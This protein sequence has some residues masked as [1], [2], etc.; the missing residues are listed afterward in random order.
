MVPQCGAARRSEI[1]VKVDTGGRLADRDRTANGLTRVA[2]LA[3]WRNGGVRPNGRVG[4][5]RRWFPSGPRRAARKSVQKLTQ[6]DV[7]RTAT[8]P[9]TARQGW[10]QQLLSGSQCLKDGLPF[11][12]QVEKALAAPRSISQTA[13]GQ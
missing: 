9:R 1:C 11:V 2:A 4:E 7:S 12:R 10:Q 6:Q 3:G 13:E 8:G 5:G